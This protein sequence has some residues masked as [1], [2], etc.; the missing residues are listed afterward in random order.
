MTDTSTKLSEFEIISQYFVNQTPTNPAIYLGSG[1]DCAL[2]KVPNDQVVAITTDTLIAGVHFPE[3][4]SPEDIGYK[5]LAVNLS[6]LAAMGA[7]PIGFTAALTLVDVDPQWLTAFSQGMMTLAKQYNIQL[8]GGDLTR[9]SIMSITITAHGFVSES[10]ALY[11]HGA[12]PGDVIFVTGELGAAGLALRNQES[13][14]PQ[15]RIAAGLALRGLA[16]SAIDVSDGLLQDLQHILVASKVGAAVNI[17]S[18]PLA[19][20]L[21]QALPKAQAI[22]LAANAGDD[23]ELVFTVAPNK[24]NA[25]QQ[26]MQNCGCKYTQIGE[27]TPNPGL[28]LLDHQQQPYDLVLKGYDHF[29]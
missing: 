22:N 3:N 13:Y 23:Y 12:K 18:L 7:T 16:N 19:A 14:R 24:I 21:S 15:P 27:I 26:A 2:M 25:L 28:C 11:R 20:K 1:D 10:Q 17:D 29:R 4:T 9:S 6:D 5:A 8:I